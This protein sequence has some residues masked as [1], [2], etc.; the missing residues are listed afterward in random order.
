VETFVGDL[1][2]LM[3]M[4]DFPRMFSNIY[5]DDFESAARSCFH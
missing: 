2:T 1:V 4:E 3:A 5:P